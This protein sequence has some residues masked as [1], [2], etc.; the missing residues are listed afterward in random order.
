MNRRTFFRWI[1][2]GWLTSAL[3]PILVACDFRRITAKPRSD[4]F[5]A[6]GNV[7]ELEQSANKLQVQVGNTQLIVVGNA[8]QPQTIGSFNPTCP[9]AGCNV[10]WETTQSQFVCPCHGAEFDSRGRVTQ[11]PA[12]KDLA[13]YSVKVEGQSILV[14][15]N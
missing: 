3:L 8:S 5:V 7:S 6:V 10:K 2:L 9:H 12:A 4:G 13:S 14:K 15:L 11:G 1:G